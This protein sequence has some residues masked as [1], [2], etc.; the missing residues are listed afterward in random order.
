MHSLSY[1]SDTISMALRTLPREVQQ[2]PTPCYRPP[3]SPT[4][5]AVFV[6][7]AG[8]PTCFTAAHGAVARPGRSAARQSADTGGEVGSQARGQLLCG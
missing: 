6:A 8:I 2:T 3:D 5:H 4:A 7:R 1:C